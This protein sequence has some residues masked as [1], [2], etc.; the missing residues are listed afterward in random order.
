MLWAKDDRQGE[1]KGG[2]VSQTNEGT[3]PSLDL[4]FICT[5][6]AS[7]LAR[8]DY[9]FIYTWILIYLVSVLFGPYLG[10]FP[11]CG[12]NQFEQKS[13]LAQGSGK[14]LLFLF[15]P[16]VPVFTAKQKLWFICCC[17]F[18]NTRS[19]SKIFSS[20][21]KQMVF[22]MQSFLS[23]VVHCAFMPK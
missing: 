8:D 18:A 1:I 21:W 20:S 3:G 11:S 2:E 14:W 9:A 10:P 7:L 17:R 5:R 6:I 22:V 23:K 19:T 15:V 4:V 16:Q 12:C 13:S